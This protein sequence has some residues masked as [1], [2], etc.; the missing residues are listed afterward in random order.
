MNRE[1]TND[2]VF[3]INTDKNQL[4]LD[5]WLPLPELRKYVLKYWLLKG[6]LDEISGQ[7]TQVLYPSL[8][9]GFLFQLGSPVETVTKD[10]ILLPRPRSFAEG[11]FCKPVK[12]LFK[13]SFAIAGI[14]FRT[15][16]MHYFLRDSESLVQNQFV[17]LKDLSGRL[18]QDIEEQIANTIELSKLAKFFDHFLLRLLPSKVS[19]DLSLR[20]A[21]DTIVAN[22]GNVR[23]T[24]LAEVAQMSRRKLER[25]FRQTFGLSPGYICKVSRFQSVLMNQACNTRD[26]LTEVAYDCGY[27]DQ[28]HMIREFKHFTDNTPTQ[29]LAKPHLIDK[30]MLLLHS[31]IDN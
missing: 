17:D 20:T 14:T 28:S 3:S 21:F 15:G 27:Y 22:S 18:A 23:V 24:T 13:G 5:W 25:Q 12:L 6:N 31:A 7:A 19:D 8:N 29:F 11:H 1:N 30:A 9:S 16:Q 4:K 10:G 26:K 2:P